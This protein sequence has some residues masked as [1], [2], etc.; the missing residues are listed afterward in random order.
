VSDR[1]DL[2]IDVTV[3]RGSIP[4]SRHRVEA[5]I[6]DPAGRLIAATPNAGVVTAFRSSAKPFQL[7]PFV[8]RG[9]AERWQLGD[10]HLAIMAAS[11]SGSHRHVAVVRDLLERFDLSESLLACGTH[12][13]LDP[14]TLADMRRDR[15]TATPLHNNCSGKHAGMLALCK[16]EGWPLEGYELAGHPLQQLLLRTVAEVCGVDPATIETGVDGCSVVVFGVPLAAM[17]TGFARLAAARPDGAAREQALAR[18]RDA[19]AAHP[20]LVGGYR[21]FDTE[22][23]EAARG[24][25]VA[26]IGAEG[27][28]C[29]AL[30]DARLGLAVKC[31]DGSPRGTSPATL[32]VLEHLGLVG[33]DTLDPMAHERRPVVLN[34]RGLQVGRV[35]ATVRSGVPAA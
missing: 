6:A 27:L 17:A 35:E 11:H 28:E 31:E 16:A 24:A 3:W 4:E 22:L 25:L 9:L 14:G 30:R 1:R 7:L 15:T 34:V 29:I 23:M 8:E 12:D 19:M 33:A 10:E 21:R 5:A 13:P 26:K 2:S 32:A 20:Y 18:I